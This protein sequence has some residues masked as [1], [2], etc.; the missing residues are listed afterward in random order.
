MPRT[1]RV[2]LT[3]LIVL[4]AAGTGCS[5]GKAAAPKAAATSAFEAKVAEAD[6]TMANGDAM[7]AFEL[8]T[9]ALKLP[10][11]ADADGSVAERQNVAKHTYLARAALAKSTSEFDP[12]PFITIIA[13]HSAAVTET[14]EAKRLLV[15][16]FFKTQSGAVR[17]DVK[18]VQTLI[19]DDESFESPHSA[20]M[21]EHM[22]VEWT[23]DFSRLPGD[24]GKQANEALTLLVKAGTEANAVMKEKWAEDCLA[25]LDAATDALDKL[26]GKL[27][28]MQP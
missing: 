18:E 1:L 25:R 11:A 13:D 14:A 7:K 4:S 19:R 16:F 15:E 9:E 17:R 23:K 24:F 3:V 12:E 2:M 27:A 6:D 10:D 26:D 8:Y 28:A 21:V 20:Y 22:A 5:T